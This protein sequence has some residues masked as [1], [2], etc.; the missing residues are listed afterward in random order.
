MLGVMVSGILI[1]WPHDLETTI[2]LIK[3]IV[4]SGK[5]FTVPLILLA[6]YAPKLLDRFLSR[7]ELSKIGEEMIS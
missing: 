2:G 7:R 1:E 4:S 3:L 6:I 5:G